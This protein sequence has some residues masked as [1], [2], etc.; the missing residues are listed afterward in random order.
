MK[1]LSS[2]GFTKNH[3]DYSSTTLV[4]S[5]YNNNIFIICSMEVNL[6]SKRL[7]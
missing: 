4:T 3:F 6:F 7:N 2:V 1:M 5:C